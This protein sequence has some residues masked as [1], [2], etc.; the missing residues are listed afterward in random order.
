MKGLDALSD[1]VSIYPI[2][3]INTNKL[4]PVTVTTEVRPTRRQPSRAVNDTVRSINLPAR[5]AREVYQQ[6]AAAFIGLARLMEEL[7]ALE[8]EEE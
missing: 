5:P 6:M 7:G 3:L 4:D 8:E 2:W 1:Q